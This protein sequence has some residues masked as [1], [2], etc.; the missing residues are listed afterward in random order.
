[1]V[2]NKMERELER[3]DIIFSKG[4]KFVI[5]E[6]LFQDFYK[7]TYKDLIQNMTTVI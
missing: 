2:A 6:I 7:D 5:G 3:G 1:M 4:S